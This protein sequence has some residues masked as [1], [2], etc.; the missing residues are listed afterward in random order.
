[1]EF[2]SFGTGPVRIR[3]RDYGY[4]ARARRVPARRGAIAIAIAIDIASPY[5]CEVL[6]VRR[7]GTGAERRSY[8]IAIRIPYERNT[9]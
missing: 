4:E 3:V 1:M 7:R 6:W 5:G 8:A 9:H 2:L